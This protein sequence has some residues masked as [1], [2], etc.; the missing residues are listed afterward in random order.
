MK[1]ITLLLG[2]VFLLSA[3]QSEN[4]QLL[5][6]G[7]NIWPGYEPLYLARQKHQLGKNIRLIEYPSASEVIRAF[8]NRSLEA[9]SLTLDEVL[10]L[11]ESNIPVKIVLVHDVSY[12]ADVMVAKPGIHSVKD[13]RGKRVGVESGALGAFFLTRALE[14]SGMSLKD[15]NVVNLDANLHED[16]FKEGR[17]DAAVTFEPVRTR[18][19]NQGYEEIFNSRQLPNEILDVLVVHSDIYERYPKRI[20]K[21]LDSWFETVEFLK[22]HENEAAAMIS[23]R[24]NLSPQEVINSYQGLV[25]LSREQNKQLLTGERPKLEASIKNIQRVLEQNHLLIK[26]GDTKDLIAGDML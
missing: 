25:L 15:I 10:S 3:C 22:H 12:G 16:A 24:L 13:L 1:R 26:G 19:L 9:A 20:R 8:R 23:K 5:R 4:Q 11:R 21:L 17:I 7:T 6:I 2:V 18:L 14:L